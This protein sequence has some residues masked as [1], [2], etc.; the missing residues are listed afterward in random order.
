M[1]LYFIILCLFLL[2]SIVGCI[3]NAVTYYRPTSNIGNVLTGHCIPT[4]SAI[5]FKLPSHNSHI[6]VRV[7]ADNGDE[8]KQVS[9][10]FSGEGWNEIHFTSANFQIHN[11]ENNTITVPSSVIAYKTDGFSNV[12]T[13]PYL[14][15]PERP[16]A[17]RFQIQINSKNPLPNSFELLSP[18]I[19]ID[20]E[21]IEFPPIRFD[22]KQWIG[23]SPLNC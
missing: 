20:G 9:I 3:P 4:D 7:W 13:E 10:F 5:E 15:P 16:G 12:F 19:V 11:I 1:K 18:T 17:F 2:S 8:I 21:D 6:R 23:I 14:A 22:K